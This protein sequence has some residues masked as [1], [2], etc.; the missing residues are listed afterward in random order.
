MP[1][2]KASSFHP[3]LAVSNIKNHVTVVLGMDNDQYP[4]WV[5]LYTNHAKS[6]RVLHHIVKPKSGGSKAP[7]TDDEKEMW[8]VLDATI[9]QWIYATVSGDLLE[10]IVEEDS[11]AMASWQRIRDIFNFST[12]NIPGQLLSNKSSPTPL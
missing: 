3:A 11:T 4:L 8:D 2:T 5:S 10:T 1:E 7:V 9:L 6:N 12:I